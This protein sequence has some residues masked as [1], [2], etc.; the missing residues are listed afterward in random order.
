M[1]IINKVQSGFEV[2]AKN[3]AG[4][5]IYNDCLATDEALGTIAELLLKCTPKYLR[6][7]NQIAGVKDDTNK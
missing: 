1:I 3:E 6:T 5:I 7:I 2:F 4:E